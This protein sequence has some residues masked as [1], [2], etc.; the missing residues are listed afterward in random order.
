MSSKP[1]G[2]PKIVALPSVSAS[3]CHLANAQHLGQVNL[4]PAS[5]AQRAK[6]SEAKLKKVLAANANGQS[7]TAP[8]SSTPGQSS[9]PSSTGTPD[10]NSPVLMMRMRRPVINSRFCAPVF[11]AQTSER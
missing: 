8:S 7:R 2:Q 1:A 4:H 10:P 9:A 11:R 6:E 5:S 3:L